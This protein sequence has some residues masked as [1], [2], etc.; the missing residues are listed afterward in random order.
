MYSHDDRATDQFRAAIEAVEAQLE[1]PVRVFAAG[2]AGS[3]NYSREPWT[4]A[5]AQD[6]S[7]E[8]AAEHGL[9]YVTYGSRNRTSWVG[10]ETFPVEA[11]TTGEEF[12]HCPT[13]DVLRWRGGDLHNMATFERGGLLFAEVE[14]RVVYDLWFLSRCQHEGF[15]WQG[16]VIEPLLLAAAPDF[17]EQQEAQRQQQLR[18]RVADYFNSV[19]QNHLATVRN[20]ITVQERNINSNRQAMTTALRELVRL[21]A[22][23]DALLATQTRSAD[24]HMREFQLL[25]DHPR[26][27]EVDFTADADVVVLS[28]D[29]TMHHPL[30]GET[31]WLGPL[32]FY[33]NTQHW[34]VRVENLHTTRQGRSHPHAPGGEPCFG[35]LSSTIGETISHGEL[36]ATFELLLQWAESFNPRDDYGRWASLWF[37]VPDVRLD[38]AGNVVNLDDVQA[39]A[40]DLDIDEAAREDAELTLEE[41][42]G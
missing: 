18:Q 29:V 4:E 42:I 41:V 11:M 34:S 9:T 13:Y 39:A 7:V 27:V 17:A 16:L 22:Q 25:V 21:Q 24:D 31:R 19:P 33:I 20:Q 10:R 6:Y 14:A 23:A 12:A 36:F 2:G 32:R 37:D 40:D 5:Q 15:D 1:V 26:A 30:T 28:D 38:E 8:F 35:N 3:L